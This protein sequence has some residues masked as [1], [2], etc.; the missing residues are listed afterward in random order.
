VTLGDSGT[1][2][3]GQLA[4]V[5]GYPFG[6]DSTMTSGIVSGLSRLL[7]VG[8]SDGS[9]LSYSIPDV[10]QTDAPINPGNSGGVLVD[11]QGAVIGVPSANISTSGSSAGVGFAIPSNIVKMVV[12]VL[13][14]SGRYPHAYLGISGGT[15]TPDLA[16]AMG[17]DPATKGILVADIQSGGPADKAGLRGSTKDV[18]IKGLSATVG[19]D[20]ITAA[21]K[22]PI[23]DFED[24]IRYLFLNKTLGDTMQLTILRDGRIQ[25]ID[26]TFAG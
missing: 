22:T 21:D 20:I 7:P 10:I 18:T 17:L 19:G 4:V 5:I 24:L 16:S 2:K 3:V 12:P 11:G 8:A 6:L 23:A 15:L 25:T 13:I 9:G 1:V 26:V 14:A